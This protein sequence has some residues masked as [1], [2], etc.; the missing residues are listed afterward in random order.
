MK[1]VRRCCQEP[2]ESAK[3]KK[4]GE[5]TGL[6]SH[7]GRGGRVECNNAP[8]APVR[9][10]E[11][12]SPSQRLTR[13]VR[14]QAGR[15]CWMRSG[16]GAETGVLPQVRGSTYEAPQSASSRATLRDLMAGPGKKYPVSRGVGLVEGGCKILEATTT[17]TQPGR[18]AW[19]RAVRSPPV[20]CRGSFF[21][22]EPIERPNP[23]D[24][25]RPIESSQRQHVAAG[26]HLLLDSCSLYRDQPAEPR[27]YCHFSQALRFLGG[28]S[29]SSPPVVAPA[30]SSPSS[31]D[32]KSSSLKASC[33][34][35]WAAMLPSA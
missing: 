34:C 29:S 31:S 24:H 5:S 12:W 6:N 23:W 28:L 18:P 27:I 20:V 15:L 26:H 7:G 32:S 4:D 2:A 17:C 10:H 13:Y 33:S 22:V 1:P 9:A 35:A 14:A 8:S 3:E 21:F 16:Y 30:P 11:H 19:H 25:P